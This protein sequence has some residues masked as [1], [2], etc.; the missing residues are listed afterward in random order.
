MNKWTCML[1][2]NKDCKHCGINSYNRKKAKPNPIN[3]LHCD[4]IGDANEVLATQRPSSR[5]IAAFDIVEQFKKEQI[6]AIFNLQEAGEHA[7]CGDKINSSGF[8][9]HPNEFSDN[10]VNYFN[11]PWPDMTAPSIPIIHNC[12]KL[13]A[14]ETKYTKKVAIHCHAGLGRTG[15][16]IACYLIYLKSYTSERAIIIVRRDR[17]GTIQ[18]KSQIEAIVSYE[19]YLKANNISYKNDFP[20]E[21]A[22]MGKKKAGKRF[23]VSRKSEDGSIG[24]VKL[25]LY[26]YI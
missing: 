16:M 4:F 23:V 12:V 2:G 5:I 17:H 8:S 10:D 7:L 20:E 21:N 19:K 15:M 25:S 14:T 26:F 6:V 24:T 13:M 22:N 3:G 1:C 9:Y 11:C 18:R